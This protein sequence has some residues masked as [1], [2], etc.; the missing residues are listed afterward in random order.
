M[1]REFVYKNITKI[2]KDILKSIPPTKKNK[3]LLSQISLLSKNT[4]IDKTAKRK[5][6]INL[7][8]ILFVGLQVGEIDLGNII[9]PAEPS[10]LIQEINFRINSGR[11]VDLLLFNDHAHIKDSYDYDFDERIE[12]L[13]NIMEL[14]TQNDLKISRSIKNMESE[15]Y[16][17]NV[18][19][20]I[21]INRE[22]AKDADIDFIA[23]CRW[24]VNFVV[25]VVELI[26]NFRL[27][28]KTTEYLV[29]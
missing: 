11:D 17:H 24:Y 20:N 13:N 18:C 27:K 21:G 7:F 9:N 12:V 2:Y 14:T 3:N 8:S 29:K 25:T 26:D 22:S 28:E 19:Y 16:V 5:K 6:L 15:W 1:E 23:D 10:K 4:S